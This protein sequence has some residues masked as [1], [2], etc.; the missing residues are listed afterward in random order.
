MLDWAAVHAIAKA[1]WGNLKFPADL[2]ITP[3]KIS[4]KPSP[5][6]VTVFF[7]WVSKSFETTA[8]SLWDC[9]YLYLSTQRTFRLLLFD[10]LPL[11]ATSVILDGNLA[12]RLRRLSGSGE[13]CGKTK[14]SWT[15]LKKRSRCK[16]NLTPPTKSPCDPKPNDVQ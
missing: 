7:G 16:V 8:A 9:L 10:L 14:A 1:V 15:V 13:K 11:C 12:W 5:K 3:K 2:K 6:S 4:P